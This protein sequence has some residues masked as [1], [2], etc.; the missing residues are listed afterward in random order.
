[1]ILECR[2]EAFTLKFA[3]SGGEGTRKNLQLKNGVFDSKEIFI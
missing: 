3:V 1:M 2:V